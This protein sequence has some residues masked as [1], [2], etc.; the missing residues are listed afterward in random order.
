M[1]QQSPGGKRDDDDRGQRG[2]EQ[3]PMVGIGRRPF[4]GPA[5]QGYKLVNIPAT[6]NRQAA[7]SAPA[8]FAM[9]REVAS[10]KMI[11]TTPENRGCCAL[12]G[13]VSVQLM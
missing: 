12:S 11:A 8:I 1:G 9:K 4:G 6:E 13:H 10:H 5:P 2:P 7:Y 3:Q